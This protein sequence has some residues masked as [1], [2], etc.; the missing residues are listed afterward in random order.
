MHYHIWTIGCQMNVADSQRAAA[1]LERLGYTPAARAEDADVVILN[2]CVVRQQPEDKAVGRLNQLRRVKERYPE[3]IL[4][5]MGCM[6]GVKETEKLQ[7]R[8]PWVDIFL[9]PSDPTELWALLAER[10]HLDEA[11]TLIADAEA[12]RL[13]L[14]RADTILPPSEQEHVVSAHLP[15]VLGCS[16]ACTYCVIPY[17]RGAERSRPPEAILAEAR[18]MAAQGVKEITLLGQI[19]DRYGYDLPEFTG[20]AETPLVTLLRQVHEIE[21]LARLRF[22][23]SHP[24]WM[25]D[26]LLRAVA[27][28]PKVCEHIE[29]PIQAGDDEVLARMRRGYTVDDYRRLVAR[30]RATIPGV[31]IATDIIVGFPGETAAQ[32]QHTYDLLAELKLDKAHVARYSSRPFTVATRTMDDNVSQEEKERRRKAL[33]DLQGRILEEL[34]A[35]YLGQTVEVLVEGRNVRQK[36]WFGRTRTDRLVFFPAEGDWRGRLAQVTITWT[37]P[38]SLIGE[39]SAD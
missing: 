38:W 23:T 39:V 32:F 15:I 26:D 11:Q 36:R 34:N 33:D 19:V 12:R 8:F 37:G 4:A 25:T 1:G 35:R 29:V 20:A 17:R 21:G 5:L 30:L 28:L 24:N 14:G 18:Q 31:S 6:V 13:A 7:A 2:T 10:G 22:L 16:H 27:E 9:P 3:R